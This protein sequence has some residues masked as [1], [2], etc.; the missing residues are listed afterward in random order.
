MS[1]LTCA[2]I[3]HY[4]LSDLG[5]LYNFDGIDLG[6]LYGF[7]KINSGKNIKTAGND[8]ASGQNKDLLGQYRYAVWLNFEIM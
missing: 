2:A 6:I 8:A 3:F 5:I 7:L 4:I 1:T